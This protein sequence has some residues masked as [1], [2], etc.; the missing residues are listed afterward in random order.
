M[1]NRKSSFGESDGG[2]G[3]T[4]KKVFDGATED[5]DFNCVAE[6]MK[7]VRNSCTKAKRT[8]Q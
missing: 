7:A 3:A 1:S 5:Y 4:E 8:I 2:K 6:Q